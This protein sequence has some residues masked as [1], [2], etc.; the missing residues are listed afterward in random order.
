MTFEN[1]DEP[2]VPSLGQGKFIKKFYAEIICW[3]IYLK[4]A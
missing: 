3:N 1:P 2:V 4:L